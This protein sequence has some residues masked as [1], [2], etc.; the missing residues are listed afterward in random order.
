ML[1]ADCGWDDPDAE[2]RVKGWLAAFF[3]NA[4]AGGLCQGAYVNFIDASLERWAEDYYGGNLQR[5]R[6]VKQAWN[7]AGGSPLRFAQE[8][9]A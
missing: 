6:D 8:V 3:A 9:P 5:L 1:Y 7:P 2:A 4:Q